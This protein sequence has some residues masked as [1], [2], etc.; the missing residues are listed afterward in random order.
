MG[1]ALSSQVPML[2]LKLTQTKSVI[3]EATPKTCSTV[4]SSAGSYC[5]SDEEEVAFDHIVESPFKS[6]SKCQSIKYQKTPTLDINPFTPQ[7]RNVKQENSW[8]R[9]VKTELCR[10]WLQ[11]LQCENQIK[12]QGCGFAHGQEEL[13]KKK[14]LS[15]QY[16]TSVCKNFLENPSKCTYG[17]RCIFQHPTKDVRVRQPYTD[18]MMDN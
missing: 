13:Q 4:G 16:L 11:G 18:M 17:A 5:N 12:E 2:D 7:K 10:F 9:K 1:K 14:T 3:G 6:I 8:K 15:R